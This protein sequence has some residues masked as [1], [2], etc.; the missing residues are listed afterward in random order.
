[1]PGTQG[2]VNL[3]DA[4]IYLTAFTFGPIAGLVA[5]GWGSAG[6]DVLGGYQVFSYASFVAHGL[7]GLAAGLVARWLVSLWWKRISAR[8]NLLE[9]IALRLA[10][11]TGSFILAWIVGTVFMVEVY[12]V[13]ESTVLVGI[14]PAIAELPFNFVQNAFGLLG[15]L[16]AVLITGFVPPITRYGLLGFWQEGHR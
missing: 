5:G 2:Y 3:G 8:E 1:M 12:F 11:S 4:F 10:F 14:R 6:A 16:V 15:V 9:R 7:Q 13:A